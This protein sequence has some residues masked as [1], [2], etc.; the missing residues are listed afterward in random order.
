MGQHSGTTVADEVVHQLARLGHSTRKIAAQT[1]LS[2]STVVRKLN[3]SPSG[4]QPEY[5]EKPTPADGLAWVAPP[6]P[7][8][9]YQQPPF[10]PPPVVQAPTEL[11]PSLLEV[12]QERKPQGVVLVIMG[13]VI[14]GLT[15]T[16]LLLGAKIRSMDTAVTPAQQPAQVSMCVKYGG[17]GVA[18]IT[19]MPAGG[20]PG[21][22]QLVVLTGAG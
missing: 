22:E 18:G 11:L 5:Q 16:V 17:H 19:A 3:R 7:S 4:P 21:N 15:I 12:R 13:F 9:P 8:G 6:P 1:G 2:Q 14:A 10:V 20:C